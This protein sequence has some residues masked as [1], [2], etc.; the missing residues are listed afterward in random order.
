MGYSPVTA[1]VNMTQVPVNVYPVLGGKWTLRGYRDYARGRNPRVLEELGI[2]QQASKAEEAR[3]TDYVKAQMPRTLGEVP[4]AVRRATIDTSLTM[5]RFAEESNRSVTALG[6][7]AR[8]RSQGKA[9]KAAIEEARD[10]IT[11]TQFVYGPADAPAFMRP[12]WTRMP[13]QFKTFLTKEMEFILNLRGAGEMARFAAALT[14]TTG[15]VGIP[16]AMLIDQVG[17]LLTGHSYLREAK[18]AVRDIPGVAGLLSRFA[19]G[20]AGMA[21]GVDIT[22]NVGFQE[23]F[24]PSLLEV[25]NML[26]PTGSDLSNLLRFAAANEGREKTQAWRMFL[27]GLSPSARRAYTVLSRP[28]AL[29]DP[30]TGRTAVDNLTPFEIGA[31]L[32]GFTPNRVAQQRDRESAVF[33]AIAKDRSLRGGFVDHIAEQMIL[34]R[35]ASNADNPAYAT[36]IRKKIQEIAVEARDADV[37]QDIIDAAR[38]R[39]QEMLQERIKVIQRDAPRRLRPQLEKLQSATPTPTPQEQ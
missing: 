30:K 10:L 26:G 31:T 25:R 6:A 1:L 29:V 35:T 12:A 21:A 11:R 13:L 20:G 5:F 38:T 22:A 7:Y 28:G 33:R 36:Q 17:D 34:L 4:G 37:G 19:V 3:L 32:L 2:R 27:S 8:A 14:A 39:A 15:A 16:G 24:S 23:F 18:V 9:H